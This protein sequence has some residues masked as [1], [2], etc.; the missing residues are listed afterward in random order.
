MESIMKSLMEPMEHLYTFDMH[1]SILSQNKIMHSSKFVYSRKRKR[2]IK[3][4]NAYYGY[5][6][7][8]KGAIMSEVYSN[9]ITL[10][11][12]KPQEKRHVSITRVMGKGQ[13]EFDYGNL[14]G[15]CKPIPDVLQ[16][17]RLIHDDSPKW[18]TIEYKQRKLEID[19]NFFDRGM[20]I[21]IHKYLIEENCNDKDK[22]AIKSKL[23]GCTKEELIDFIVKWNNRLIRNSEAF[24]K[25]E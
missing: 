15:G 18:V 19:D 12:D 5:K 21:S 1:I 25:G 9:N 7:T 17:L 22:K 4:N 3:I 14:V 6:K 2:R 13:R 16:E 8:I 23:K 11:H 24:L 10:P 20:I